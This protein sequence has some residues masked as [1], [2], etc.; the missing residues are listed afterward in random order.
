[1]R[2]RESRRCSPGGTWGRGHV[3]CPQRIA[4]LKLVE[5]GQLSRQPSCSLRI[6]QSHFILMGMEENSVLMVSLYAPGNRASV[7]FSQNH[8]QQLNKWWLAHLISYFIIYEI[9]DLISQLRNKWFTLINF[10]TKY[11]NLSKMIKYYPFF[12]YARRACPSLITEHPKAN[13]KETLQGS[14]DLSP[15][16]WQNKNAPIDLAAPSAHLRSL[17]E[18]ADRLLATGRAP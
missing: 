15:T 14:V 6:A 2:D 3:S 10:F 16:P 13:F 18:E 17:V 11:K 8:L 7:Q 5:A 4:C 12:F 9:S 1:M